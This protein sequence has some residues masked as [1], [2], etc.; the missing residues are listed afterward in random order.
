MSD[1]ELRSLS[2]P[3]VALDDLKG[4]FGKHEMERAAKC[5][6][7]IARDGGLWSVRFGPLDFTEDDYTLK[8]FALLIGYGWLLFDEDSE[9]FY[10]DSSFVE[11]VTVKQS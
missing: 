7:Q 9:E 2:D 11:R 1:Q 6:I 3:S 8:G 4:I 5:I 10:V